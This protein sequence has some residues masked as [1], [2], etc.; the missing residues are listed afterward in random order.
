MKSKCIWA[1]LVGVLGSAV[2]AGDVLATAATTPPAPSTTILGQSRF[3][4]F[5]VDARQFC[6]T[7]ERGSKRA[8]SP[9]STS[10]TTSSR[11]EPRPDGTRTPDPA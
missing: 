6:P 8:G 2:Y 4:S 3:D 5:R 10:S 11:P 1:L 9:T 7:G